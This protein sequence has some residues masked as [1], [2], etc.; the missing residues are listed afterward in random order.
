[1]ELNDFLGDLA[2]LKKCFYSYSFE[3]K[4][5]EKLTNMDLAT[6]VNS[7]VEG[8]TVKQQVDV[9][10]KKIFFYKTINYL[11]KAAIFAPKRTKFIFSLIGNQ[12][13]P[14][15]DLLMS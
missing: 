3:L 13:L 5:Q 2:N 9:T 10:L 4:G 11:K 7:G 8:G 6:T 14:H 15:F 12:I 1:M